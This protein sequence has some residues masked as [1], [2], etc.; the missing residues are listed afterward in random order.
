MRYVLVFLVVAVLVTVWNIT[1]EAAQSQKEEWEDYIEIVAAE[2]HICQELIEAVIERESSWRPDVANGSC[3]GLMQINPEYHAERME[4]L[5]VEN[6]LDPYDNI[7]VGT[8][9]LAELFQEYGD[10]YA[11]LM[12]YNAGYDGLRAWRAGEYS[13]YAVEVAERSA[14]LEREHGK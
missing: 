9:F 6:L 8:D 4:R 3:I 2:Y 11:V 7:L 5:G 10:I 1:V 13:D 12:Y 14:E